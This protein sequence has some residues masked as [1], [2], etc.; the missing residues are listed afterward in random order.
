V[1]FF[2]PFDEFQSS[3]VPNSLAA[4]RGYRDLAVR[5]IE[6]RNQRIAIWWS[7]RPV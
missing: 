7:A 6:A 4:Y 1:R 3:P 2:T 5:F